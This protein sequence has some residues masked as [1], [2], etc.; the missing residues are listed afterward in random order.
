MVLRVTAYLSHQFANA[1]MTRSL[2]PG[3]I[4]PCNSPTAQPNRNS[5]TRSMGPYLRMSVTNPSLAGLSKAASGLTAS[6]KAGASRAAS[7][8]ATAQKTRV[9]FEALAR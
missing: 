8:N 2:A 6:A 9:R 4:R 3:F 7:Q 1:A 5:G